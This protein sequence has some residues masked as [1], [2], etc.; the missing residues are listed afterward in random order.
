M[1]IITAFLIIVV[2][3]SLLPH[4]PVLGSSYL[5]LKDAYWSSPTIVLDATNTFI[6]ELENSYQGTISGISATLT[7][8]DLAGMDQSGT[9]SYTGSLFYGQTVRMSFDIFIPSGSTASHYKAELTIDYSVDG[10]PTTQVIDLYVTIMGNPDVKCSL[11]GQVRPGHTS[12][13]TLTVKNVGDG[14]AR[15]V[16]VTITPSS[17]DVY[18]SSPIE[19]GILDPDESRSYSVDLYVS[20]LADEAISLTTTV[21]WLDQFGTAGQYTRLNALKVSGGPLPEITVEPNQTTLEPG[22]ENSI[23][24]VVRNDGNDYAYNIS[25]TLV[26]PPELS[27]RG[28][29]TFKIDHLKPDQESYIQTTLSVSPIFGGP[30]Q[31]PVIVEYDDSGEEH[32]TKSLTMGFYVKLLPG[33]Y[34]V[35]YSDKR[36]IFPGSQEF[37]GI[38]LRNEGDEAARSI[39]VDFIPSKDLAILSA[40]GAQIDEL[41][42]GEAVKMNVLVSCPNVTYGSLT[43]TLRLTYM[44]EHDKARNQ[45]IPISL[46]TEEPATPLIS[47]SP[48]NQELKVDEVNELKVELRNEG[49][50]ASDIIVKIA[51]PSPEL[52]AIVGPDYAYVEYLDKNE[53][54]EIS[55]EVYL[56]PKAYGAV[57]LILHV[58]YEDE[59]G[60]THE[61]VLSLGVRAVGEPEIEVAHVSTI[62]SSIYPGDLNVRLVVTLTNVGNYMAKEVRANI[63]RIP[64]VI[65]PSSPGT[66]TFL[67][68][69]LPPNEAVNVEFIVDISE[70]A[71]PG[72]YELILSTKYG[73]SSIPVQIE[74]K[75]SFKLLQLEMPGSPKPGDKGVK[76]SLVLQNEARATAEDVVVE[77]ITPY[78]VGTTTSAL[79][80]IPG[81]SNMT[82]IMEVDIDK[83]APQ[84]VPVDIKVTWKQGERSLYQTISTELTL[85]KENSS[86]S[87]YTHWALIAGA[88]VLILVILA[89]KIRRLLGL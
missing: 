76:L 21:T 47:A 26:P 53:K 35:A 42:P 20:D 30:L 41:E 50:P 68:P 60:R 85:A 9:A 57:Q 58:K 2:A 54:T 45:V 73:N 74:E 18:V 82:A 6:V 75:A 14:V 3:L 17:A 23:Y 7:V 28:Q 8:Y 12:T 78:L 1:R 4:I 19:V 27:V 87:A 62:P 34:L 70:D 25:V 77:I 71:K 51:F 80:E 40:S 88:V 38:T 32:H 61:D 13:V 37:I 16:M 33:P 11:S 89:P 29:S 64:G 24:L 43:L 46:I 31:L 52:G 83:N 72:R 15:R 65:E 5:L 67:I 66:D 86:W 49:G 63:S 10:N 81:K 84:I 79:G 44:D 69:A 22:R 39:R 59:A 56:S 36:V 48:I 55:Y